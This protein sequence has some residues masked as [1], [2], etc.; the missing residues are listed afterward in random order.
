MVMPWIA[1]PPCV[2]SSP[3]T[4]SKLNLSLCYSL[5]SSY[6]LYNHLNYI[7][8][9]I[10]I[11]L[12]KFIQKSVFIFIIAITFLFLIFGIYLENKNIKKSIKDDSG[13][14]ATLVFENLYNIMKNGGNKEKIEK[15][16][17]DIENRMP[18]TDI[19]IIRNNDMFDF[20]RVNNVYVTKKEDIYQH[21]NH[22]DFA[23]PILFKQECLSCHKTSKV[24][25]VAGVILLEY[26]I[27]NLQLPIKDIFIMIAI[28][29]IIIV[30]VFV[31]LWY[32]LLKKYFVS[33]IH[34]LAKKIENINSYEDLETNIFINSS[35]IE[36]KQIENSF[37]M[38]NQ[39]LID[40]YV[41]LEKKSTT[42]ELTGVLNRRKFN[43][44]S[45]FILKNAKRYNNT[46]CIAIADLNKFKFIND[47]YGHEVG[48]EILILFS[49]V[50]L[51]NIRESDYLFRVGGDEFILL[52][53]NTDYKNSMFLIEKL[54][55]ELKKSPYVYN[56]LKIFIDAS[57]GLSEYLIDGETIKELLSVSDKRMYE[58][59][60]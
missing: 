44:Y 17:K 18:D 37:N 16:I 14:I 5:V 27:L 28:L 38:Q 43:K 60:I 59:K 47:N 53:P 52:L 41:S 2:G 57:F 36:I 10:L 35:I 23:S 55:K 1:N 46:F 45:T 25:D 3:A 34:E 56:D 39:K 19:K 48:D 33:P 26:P 30:F 32:Y 42:D 22:I 29:F 15:A 4:S 51:E 13:V 49:K 54:K 6:I 12:N 58:N 24:G 11:T 9:T 21:K 7:K 50:V 40:S 8:E 20:D 31:L